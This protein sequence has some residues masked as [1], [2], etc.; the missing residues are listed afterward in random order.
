MLEPELQ[1]LSHEEARR[2]LAEQGPN[3]LPQAQQ[4]ALALLLHTEREPMFLLSLGASALYLA[5]GDWQAGVALLVMAALT[6]GLALFQE[7]RT[8]RA[9]QALRELSSPRALVLREGRAQRI[10][11][12]AVVPGD[13]LLLAEGDR[14]AADAVL[15]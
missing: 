10:A 9:L 15:L 2:R 4:A 13:L 5:L 12:S 8:E 11:G 1:G 14:I 3:S 7:G 6:I